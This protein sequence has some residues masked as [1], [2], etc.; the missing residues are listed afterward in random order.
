MEPLEET[1]SRLVADTRSVLS[2]LSWINLG[3]GYLW[4]TLTNF[5]PLLDAVYELVTEFDLDVF[6]EPGAGMV[7]AAGSLTS[8]VV[9]LFDHGGKDIAVLDTTVNHLPEVFEYQYEPDILQHVEGAPHTY[10][11]TGCSCLAG[12]LFGEYDFEEPLEI[13][14]LVTFTN[15]GAYSLVKAHSFNG[16]PIPN[17]YVLREDDRLELVRGPDYTASSTP[18]VSTGD[19]LG[20]GHFVTI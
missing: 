16:I 1:V 11:L 9:D 8:L 19:R 15:V 12:D 14:S 5:S 13:G 18:A 17:V 6:I 4:D 3:G 2:R 7:N 20:A 10:L